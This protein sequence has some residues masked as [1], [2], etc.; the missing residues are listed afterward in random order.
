MLPSPTERRA[1]PGEGHV[2]LHLTAAACQD[3]PWV[4][5]AELPAAMNHGPGNGKAPAL[6]FP[7]ALVKL[8][9]DEADIAQTAPGRGSACPCIGQLEAP[10]SCPLR[11]PIPR[12]WGW[13]GTFEPSFSELGQG[14]CSLSW[15]LGASR[16]HRIHCLSTFPLFSYT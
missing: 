11:V 16:P 12:A 6:V 8:Q 15:L 13:V 7:A 2:E 5:M 1:V 14:S 3:E 10:S 4:S 9:S